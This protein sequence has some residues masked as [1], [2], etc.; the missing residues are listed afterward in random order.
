M[1][2]MVF[3]GSSS[4]RS[5]SMA[6]VDLVFDN[7]DQSLPIDHHEVTITRKLYRSGE[8]EYLLNREASRL[9]DIRELFMDTG[10]GVDAYSVIEQGRVD[11]L[12]QSSPTERRTIF[13]EAA[14]ISKYKAR[15]R[16]AERKLERTQ[17][18]LLRV[19]DIIE[20]MEKRLRSVR[21]QAGKARRFKEHEARL[22]ELRST[23]SLAEY[24]RFTEEIGR[25]T[26]EAQT[27]TDRATALR[28]E[29]D[30]NEAENSQVTLRLDQLAEEISTADNQL[31]QA[32]SDL[33]A[34]QERIEAAGRRAEEQQALRGRLRERLATD[35]QRMAEARSELD[36]VQQ[37]AVAL[38]QQTHDRQAEIDG[39]HERDQALA[40]ELTEAQA[41]LEDEK[42]G[43][44]DLLRQSAQTHNEIIR[45][46]THR[47]SLLG[48]KGRLSQRDEQISSELAIQLEQRLL[49][50]C[51]C[52]RS[53]N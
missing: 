13:E 27:R 47:E 11:G 17:Q 5:S 6:Q 12:L 48:Q 31:V 29:I 28:T 22:N 41:I 40:R 3:N 19:A 38:Q 4:R 8:S 24:H 45:L 33:A 50:K 46:N 1:L 16:E 2:D 49:W 14:G 7:S 51:V 39:L 53:R 15:R 44:I 25:L 9:K 21:L 34:Q 52:A 42:A 32:K 10:V 37:A 18:N 20:E 43:I 36:E 23:F 30:R 26:G 35:D